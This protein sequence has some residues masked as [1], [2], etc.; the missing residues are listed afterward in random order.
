MKNNNNQTYKTVLTVVAVLMLIVLVGGGTYAWW[1]WRSA[2]NT[3]VNITVSGGTYTLDGG[4]SITG[5]SL[6]PTDQCNGNY[7]IVRT[8][9]T[10]TTNTTNTNMNAKIQL[11]PSVFPAD[12]QSS[13]LKWYINTTNSCTNGGVSG[14]FGSVVQGTKF[15]LTSFTV[16]AGTTTAQN[17]TFYL[18]IW[19]DSSYEHPNTGTT[20]SDPMQDKA[21]TLQLTGEMTN[22]PGV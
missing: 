5:K 12:L 2:N 16:N 1:T 21:F 19:L 6:V 17:N 20:V 10:K 11:N 4:G 7:A 8:I 13:H 18:F 22:E 3:T 15:D 14:D 9:T